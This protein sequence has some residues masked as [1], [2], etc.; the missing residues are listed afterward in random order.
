MATMTGQRKTFIK[1][2]QNLDEELVKKTIS[3][4][5]VFGQFSI[6]EE[7]ESLFLSDECF[8]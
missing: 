5:D 3:K 2:L 4:N 6:L 1:L 8:K 7:T